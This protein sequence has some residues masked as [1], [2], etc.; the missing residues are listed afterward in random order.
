MTSLQQTCNKLQEENK[1]LTEELRQLK[2]E[3]LILQ[4]DLREKQT[5]FSTRVIEI[6]KK[7]FDDHHHTIQSL[8]VMKSQIHDQHMQHMS[9][10][11]SHSA[12]SAKLQERNEH[13][14]KRLTDSGAEVQQFRQEREQLLRFKEDVTTLTALNDFLRKDRSE[15][16]NK[17]TVLE[18]QN[19]ECQV[20][21]KQ[22]KR[23]FDMQH[24]KDNMS[25]KRRE[26]ASIV[27]D[28]SS[29]NSTISRH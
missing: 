6:T 28:S 12:Q 1:K 13:I 24:L 23:K 26:I 5:E 18:R 4:R 8:D 9:E 19:Q 29:N 25:E 3:L 17:V 21:N 27:T 7:A 2:Q 14:T 10:V 16:Q 11:A 22:L 20:E 15:L